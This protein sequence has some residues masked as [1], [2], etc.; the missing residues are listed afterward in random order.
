MVDI[1]SFIRFALVGGTSGVMQLSLT[2]LFVDGLHLP[3]I[4]GSSIAFILTGVY[5]YLMHY[6][7]SFSSDIPHGLVLIKYLMM[8]LGAMI[9]NGVVMQMGV[10]VFLVHYLIVQIAAAVIVVA[11]TFCISSLWVFTRKN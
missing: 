2:W 9:I 3:V 7:W 5:N 1:Q 6:F 4:L 8:C 11:W 10:K